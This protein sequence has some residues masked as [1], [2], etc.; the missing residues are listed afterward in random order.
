VRPPRR[1][2]CAAAALLAAILLGGCWGIPP[3]EKSG[4]VMLMGIDQAGEAYRV[5]LLV[6]RP[7]GTPSSGFGGAAKGNPATLDEA[8]APT[9]AQAIVRIRAASPLYLDFTHLAVVVVSSALARAGLA[10]PLALAATT[11]HVVETPWLLVARDTSAVSILQALEDKLPRPG[12]VAVD[13]I[14]QARLGTP[15]RAGHLFT[16][17]KE[18]SLEGDQFAT[19]GAG[20][21]RSADGPRLELSGVALFRAD[22]LVGWLDGGAAWGWLLATGRAGR[23]VLSVPTPDGPVGL[24]V[25]GD[26]RT[27]RV[28]P[29][30]GG[31]TATV[32]VR[33]GAAVVSLPPG[34]A[35]FW[36]TPA[37]EEAVRGAAES[38]I[39][40]DVAAALAAARAAGADVFS[41]GEFVRVR[42]P[43]R[44]EAVASTWNTEG[45]RRLPVGIAVQVALHSLGEAACPVLG[46]C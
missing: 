13:T 5:S 11:A 8:T 29:L 4:L 9:V 1:G 34:P 24:Q 46:A 17:L 7:S 6:G 40:A 41:L 30:A 23:P 20:L 12:D 39:A 36:R 3:V 28:S 26:R 37:Q 19:A 21:R 42:D 31:P 35:D 25:L 44:W 32:T 22:R 33:I 2:L 16:L 27:I 10:D 14:V 43:R 18:M 45:F 38:A 15:Y